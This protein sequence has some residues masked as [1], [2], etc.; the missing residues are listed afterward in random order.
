M[1]HSIA[2][3]LVIFIAISCINS[4]LDGLEKKVKQWI[5]KELLFPK[6]VKFTILGTDTVKYDLSQSRYRIVSYID[7]MGCISCKL[8]LKKWKELIM[9]LDSIANHQVTVSLF[10][11]SKNVRDV[12]LVLERAKFIHPVCLDLDNSFYNLNN[13]PSELMF[14]TFLIDEKNKVLAIGNPIHNF[15][16]KMLYWDIIK[17][18]AVA[19]KHKEREV[20]KTQIGIDNT[21]VWLGNFNWKEEQKVTF[22]L[23]NKGDI[24]LLIENVTTSCGCTSVDYDKKPMRK[25]EIMF[26]NVK[27]KAEHPEYLDK[28]IIVYCNVDSSPIRLRIWGN[29]VENL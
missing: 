15:K 28:T 1:K 19:S 10:I 18:E 3:L 13:F 25:N 7:S 26:L 8:Q 11:H 4:N 12:K 2:V 29:A 21:S 16:V 27:Y 23:E 9:E 6:D 24:P 14:Q 5:G 22:K 17:G 20:E